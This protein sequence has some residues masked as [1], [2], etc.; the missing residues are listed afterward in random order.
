MWGN[1]GPHAGNKQLYY[2]GMGDEASSL[3]TPQINPCSE[4]KK[5][6]AG[7]NIFDK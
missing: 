3:N 2:V 7:P 4:K 1:G 5:G 6:K